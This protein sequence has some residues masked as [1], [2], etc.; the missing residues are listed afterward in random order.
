M[1]KKFGVSEVSR[2]RAMKSQIFN[3]RTASGDDSPELD[4]LLAEMQE[5]WSRLSSQDKQEIGSFSVRGLS[6]AP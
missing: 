2:F 1:F 5:V 6:F 3:L 4:L